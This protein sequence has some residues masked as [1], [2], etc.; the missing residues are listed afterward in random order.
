[1]GVV[2]IDDFRE[3]SLGRCGRERRE[4]EKRSGNHLE[5]GCQN[6]F[7]GWQGEDSAQP[8]RSAGTLVKVVFD[9]AFNA[10]AIKIEEEKV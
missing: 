9:R 7:Q 8:A 3:R 1:V 5:G 6:Q 2:A 10:V 4:E